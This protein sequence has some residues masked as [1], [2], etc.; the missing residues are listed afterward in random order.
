MAEYEKIG[1]V[2]HVTPL[3]AE[4]MGHLEDGIALAVETAAEASN[5]T[6][7]TVTSGETPSANIADGKLNLVFEEP[8]KGEKGDP[9]PAGANGKDGA[10]GPA[11]ADG[12][13]GKNGATWY[14]VAS[15]QSSGGAAPSG[16]AEGDF[17]LDSNGAVYKVNAS[18]MLDDTGVN[19]KG[20]QGPSGKDGAQGATGA[21][22]PKGPKGDPGD[23]YTLPDATTSVRG[24][25]LQAEAQADSVATDATGLVTDFNALLA[26]LRT[27][28]IL[29]SS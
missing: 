3:N 25:V 14:V 11:G 8:K 15:A 20:A 4:N 28:G 2:D 9:G 17:V 6:I 12:A 19:I 22:G 29:A 10:Q 1:F 13:P 24:G 5:L 18:T 16:A 21:Q 7:G 27:A 23:T 26:K